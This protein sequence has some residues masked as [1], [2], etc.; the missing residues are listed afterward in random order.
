MDTQLYKKMYQEIYSLVNEVDPGFL[1]GPEDEYDFQVNG[2][3][4]LIEDKT[5]RE[6]LEEKLQKIF[7]GERVNISDEEK[8]K[9]ANLSEKLVSYFK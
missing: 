7:F 5:G 1:N 3:I 9:I 2:I 6:G 4:K 8:L